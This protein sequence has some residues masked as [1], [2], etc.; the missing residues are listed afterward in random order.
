VQ[1]KLIRDVLLA[2]TMLFL[3][4]FVL[5][6]PVHKQ[7]ASQKLG[8][9]SIIPSEFAGWVG[10]T[11]DTTKYQGESINELLVRV[12]SQ[13]QR[14]AQLDFILEYSSDLRKNF[15]IHFPENC[16]RAWGN[17]VVLLE[18]TFFDVAGQKIPAKTIFVKGKDDGLIKTDKLVFYWLVMDGKLMADTVTIRMDQML[19]GVFNESR[20]GFLVRVDYSGQ[21]F[22]FNQDQMARAQMMVGKFLSDLS[23]TTDKTAQE[24]LFGSK[25]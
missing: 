4:G 21:D 16:H 5:A 14:N 6:H 9:A 12:Y 3:G 20:T 18:P 23:G 2:G 19:A 15:S 1:T 25:S 10:T 7:D 8:L 17:E 13:N 11:Q 22:H 24:M